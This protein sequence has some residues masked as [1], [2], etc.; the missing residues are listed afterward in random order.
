[1]IGGTPLADP[2]GA[3]SLLAAA[4]WARALMTGTAATMVATLAVAAVGVLMLQG[5]LP[6]RRGLV[7]VMGC[8]TIFGASTIA[9]GLMAVGQQG[10]GASEVVTS[11]PSLI[12][13]VTPPQPQVYDPYAGAS[14]PV[15]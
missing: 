12:R 15:L 14:V 9:S 4:S 7:V 3:G 10:S 13:P 1:M 6:L 5:R 11:A 8:F 2:T